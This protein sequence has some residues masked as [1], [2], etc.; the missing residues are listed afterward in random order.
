MIVT[1]L[2]LFGKR[3]CWLRLVLGSSDRGILEKRN[4]LA[5][6]SLTSGSAA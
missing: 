3:V 5:S 2:A 6:L 4:T 1:D